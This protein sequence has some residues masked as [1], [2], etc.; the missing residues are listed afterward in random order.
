MASQDTVAEMVK[1]A[2]PE[3][4]CVDADQVFHP[5]EHLPGRFVSECRQENTLRSHAPLDKPR[6]F[7]RQG[8]RLAAPR[9][10]DD[11]HG[12]VT[13]KNHLELLRVQFLF[14]V[15]LSQYPTFLPYSSMQYRHKSRHL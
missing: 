12:T 5:R 9:P 13:G 8:P 14:I 15:Y 6:D 4:A 1:S 2:A 11:K 7:V 3:A 10:G